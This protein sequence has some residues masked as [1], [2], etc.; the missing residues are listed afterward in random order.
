MD[1]D[2]EGP[3]HGP[4]TIMQENIIKNIKKEF[5]KLQKEFKNG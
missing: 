5:K 2:T 3:K 1:T 4:S